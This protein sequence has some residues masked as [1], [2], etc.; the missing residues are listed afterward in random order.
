M[1]ATCEIELDLTQGLSMN[2]TPSDS[3]ADRLQRLEQEAAQLAEKLKQA[4]AQISFLQMAFL[5]GAAVLIGGGY[6]LVS[7]GRLRIE[8]VSPGVVKS[9]EAKE[10]GLYNRFNERVMFDA[11]DKFGMPR[12]TLLDAEKRL[13]MRVMVFPEGNGTGG[14]VLYDDR[15]YRGV[16]RMLEG[17][18][19]SLS[20]LGTDRKGGIAMT[21]A[22]DGTPSLKMTDNAGK[23]LWEAPPKS[24]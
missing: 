17:G 1:A 12:I 6:Y 3:T 23:V 11:D 8:G 4:S 15:E 18:T 2:Q 24:N 20:L 16:F 5:I 13:R 9:V 22:P 7:T 21:V 14:L 19:V 10:F